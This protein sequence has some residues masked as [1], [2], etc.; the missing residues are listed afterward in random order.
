MSEE[1]PKGPDEKPATDPWASVPDASSFHVASPVESTSAILGK[2]GAAKN[3]YGRLVAAL[4][5]VL[6]VVAVG[7]VVASRAGDPT[8]EGGVGRRE[9]ADT[10]D[11]SKIDKDGREIRFGP[12]E[13]DPTTG[14]KR[15]QK[16]HGG[17]DDHS[18]ASAS[19][20]QRAKRAQQDLEAAPELTPEQMALLL[21][22]QADRPRA[23]GMATASQ[24]KLD[25]GMEFQ[26][27]GGR[28][29]PKAMNAAIAKA[30][31]A[32]SSCITNALRRDPGRK[33]R[34]VR[35]TATVEPSGVISKAVFDKPEAVEG[36]LGE[37]LRKTVKGIVFPAFEGGAADIVIPIAMGVTE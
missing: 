24:L 19:A 28:I 16:R 12:E 18:G 8:L 27:A 22:A 20:S 5:A 7:V 36:E 33:L 30:Q 23:G 31:P 11:W 13:V 9:A 10:V 25:G 6:V 34:K 15:G 1:N 21:E 2:T 26:T 4:V 29:D 3:S 14:K 32:L 35:V 17:D 37:C